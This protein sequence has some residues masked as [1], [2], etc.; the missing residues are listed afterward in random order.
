M[1]F[2]QKMLLPRK[3]PLS[4]VPPPR[5]YI[6]RSPVS[7]VARLTGLIPG[8]SGRPLTELSDSEL[9]P[10]FNILSNDDRGASEIRHSTFLLR[11][12]SW[13]MRVNDIRDINVYKKSL[14]KNPA[15]LP[16]L[17]KSLRM[18]ISEFFRET[19]IFF[20]IE[21]L[22]LPALSRGPSSSGVHAFIEQ[23][24][25]A[26]MAYSLA[27][28]LQFQKQL[29]RQSY[30]I[31]IAA[32]GENA[33][34]EEHAGNILYPHLVTM[35]LSP[36]C[37][38]MF[39]ETTSEGY[40][41][42]QFLQKSVAFKIGKLEEIAP[43]NSYDIFIASSQSSVPD[44][45]QID[46]YHR[47]MSPGGFLV[48]NPSRHAKNMSAYFEVVD[49][50]NGIYRK[51]FRNKKNIPSPIA[52]QP[53][54]NQP[55]AIASMVERLETQLNATQERLD[56]TMG[57]YSTTH[58]ELVS[59]NQKLQSSIQQ[60]TLEKEHL[61]ARCDSL[62]TTLA[63]VMP[64]YNALKQKH[65]ELI[66]LNS[67][68]ETV[69]ALCDMGILYLNQE[70]CIDMYTGDIA[71]LFGLKKSDIGR[72]F[73]H[74]ESPFQI[75]LAESAQSVLRSRTPIE[76][77]RR[78]KKGAWYRIKISPYI[79]YDNVSG[80]VCSFLDITESKREN[81]WDRFKGKILNQIQDAII[82]TNRTGH[83]TFIN[84]AAISRFGLY[85]KKKS[86]FLIADLYQSV[87]KS[88][89]AEHVAMEKLIEEG[90]WSGELYHV[91]PNGPRKRVRVTIHLLEDDAGKEIGQLTVIR[92]YLFVD[93]AENDA[94]RRII[95]DLAER[96]ESIELAD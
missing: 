84:K 10:L 88:P 20:S 90:D 13:R 75:N 3:A 80:V 58:D 21:K 91:T 89:E 16:T 67:R 17:R 44:S 19:D 23:D 46:T 6:S 33:L 85:H 7:L 64:A 40:C 1:N 94:L 71:P 28:L 52:T 37:L 55:E 73:S 93:H 25:H 42:K 63:N 78:T 68:L 45:S 36:Q 24:E 56:I 65:K 51:R 47:L 87:W 83:V 34:P 41:V 72:P 8:L 95:E 48:L 70:L 92:D 57:E 5:A 54:K 4:P 18:N 26:S 61:N 50:K 35:D 66:S 15:E 11:R 59:M 77:E 43:I 14:L 82:V 29:N 30:T 39:F 62:H 86:G 96:N 81:E 38:N 9:A 69:I 2:S 22:V 32:H 49:S 12:I 76:L 60:L 79:I 27:M 74:L 53:G 31:R